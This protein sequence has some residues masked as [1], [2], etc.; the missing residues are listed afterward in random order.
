MNKYL[1]I[2][3]IFT[4]SCVNEKIIT[5]NSYFNILNTKIDLDRFTNQ[6]YFQA[7]ID[8]WNGSE[9]IKSVIA[10][11]SILQD[12]YYELLGRFILNDDGENGDIIQNNGI[13]TLL[14]TADQFDLPDIN[15]EIKSVNM[16]TEYEL[17]YSNEDSLNIELIVSGK[18]LKVI[19]IAEDLNGSLTQSIDYVNL[20]NSYIE[21]Q[22]NADGMYTDIYPENNQICEREW[23]L[24]D[25]G[26]VFYFNIL[27]YEQIGSSNN[28]IYSTKI[29]FRPLNECGGTGLALFKFNIHDMDFLYCLAT[30]TN[31]CSSNLTSSIENSLN[32]Y[33]CGDNYCSIDYETNSSCIEDCR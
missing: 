32:I 4:L 25:A 23:D 29:P 15:P 22:I 10:D 16:P 11:I 21:I 17:S 24:T 30:E 18:S 26:F 19:F 9:N 27:S 20:S 7:E 14:T 12:G 8:Y 28:F 6:L 3:F 5:N 2:I 13:F 33:G 1:F 31:L